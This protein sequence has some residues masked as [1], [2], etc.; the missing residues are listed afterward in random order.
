MPKKSYLKILNGNDTSDDD[1]YMKAVLGQS[2]QQF[3]AEINQGFEKN[4]RR[5]KKKK[6]E[7]MAIEW[8]NKVIASDRAEAKLYPILSIDTSKDNIKRDANRRK[9]SI[10][11]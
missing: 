2:K 11:D 3:E 4:I 7:M 6:E 8:S 9:S 10:Y 5:Y 1:E